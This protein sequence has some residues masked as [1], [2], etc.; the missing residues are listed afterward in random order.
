[1]TRLNSARAKKELKKLLQRKWVLA[2]F[3]NEKNLIK[4]V[5]GI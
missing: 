3:K 4:E 5:I 2:H 1:M